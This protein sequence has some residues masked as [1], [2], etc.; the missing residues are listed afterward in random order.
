MYADVLGFR[1]FMFVIVILHCHAKYLCR[2]FVRAQL[3]IAEADDFAVALVGH[4]LK[5]DKSI[6]T[7][8]IVEIYLYRA[9]FFFISVTIIIFFLMI[10][11]NQWLIYGHSS[12]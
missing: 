5:Y 6:L 10:E 4:T 11:K 2:F 7:V 8:E 12:L 9:E 1:Q 3:Q